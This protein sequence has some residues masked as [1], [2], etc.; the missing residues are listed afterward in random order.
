MHGYVKSYT[1]KTTIIGFFSYS[2]FWL[3]CI[4]S[5]VSKPPTWKYVLY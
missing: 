2:L 5:E 1:T 3:Q 4:A